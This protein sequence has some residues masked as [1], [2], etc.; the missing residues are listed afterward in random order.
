MPKGR[1]VLRFLSHGN[2]LRSAEVQMFIDGSYKRKTK[3]GGACG[4]DC[5][6]SCGP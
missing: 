3:H 1:R 6:E 5:S 4:N 2:T